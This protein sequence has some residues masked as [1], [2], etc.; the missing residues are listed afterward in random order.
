MGLYIPIRKVGEDAESVEYSF[1]LRGATGRV[2]I[3]KASGQYVVME[4]L[5]GD[6][7]GQFVARVIYKLQKH[8]RS[9]DLPDRTS[10]SA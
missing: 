2:R 9:G 4:V 10:W 6:Q 5:S 7:A 8:W 1:S 3:D